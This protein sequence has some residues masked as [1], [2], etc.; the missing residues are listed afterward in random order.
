MKK[1]IVVG[2]VICV[3]ISFCGC[4][5]ERIVNENNENVEIENYMP[6]INNITIRTNSDLYE[7][8]ENISIILSNNGNS[9]IYYSLGYYDCVENNT[10]YKIYNLYKEKWN[11]I[12]VDNCIGS[13]YS[14]KELHKNQSASFIWNQK[15][16]VDGIPNRQTYPGLYKISFLCKSS[17]EDNETV[18]IYSEN[19][20]INGSYFPEEPT[21]TKYLSCEQLKVNITK[22][23]T[24]IDYMP[25][26]VNNQ[27]RPNMYII[28]E[29]ENNAGFDLNDLFIYKAEVVL[30][31]EVIGD[32]WPMFG[33]EKNCTGEH[34][35]GYVDKFDIAN[36]C[37]MKIVM[38]KKR[39]SD[40][41][42]LSEI[43]RPNIILVNESNNNKSSS[44]TFDNNGKWI[45]FRFVTEEYYTDIYRTSN[46]EFF[47]TS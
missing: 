1:N 33:I 9:S 3:I 37:S 38:Y 24:W 41:I 40:N 34:G 18:E 15:G 13:N 2:I 8:G 46:P 10:S 30:N 32:F 39:R 12:M 5:T 20:T 42:S 31:G 28:F 29:I 26:L 35:T 11:W 16:W 19:I 47:I 25:F 44:D 14:F 45:Q 7:F 23:V 4:I 36:G 43:V 22:F 27:G 6:S 17:I 21:P